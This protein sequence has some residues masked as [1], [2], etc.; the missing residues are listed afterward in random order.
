MKHER[1]RAKRGQNRFAPVATVPS[2]ELYGGGGGFRLSRT[3]CT[4]DTNVFRPSQPFSLFLSP[5]YLP[6][7]FLRV[8]PRA[9]DLSRA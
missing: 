5:L 1:H 3:V 2:L 9:A 7:P 6:K 4:D 8:A